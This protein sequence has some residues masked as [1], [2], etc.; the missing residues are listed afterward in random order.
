[1][2]FAD[3]YNSTN[4]ESMG[5]DYAGILA[6]TALV[7]VITRGLVMSGGIESILIAAIGAMFLFAAIGW[8]IGNVAARIVDESVRQRINAELEAMEQGGKPAESQAPKTA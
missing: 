7:T 8:L 3:R 4:L 2:R 5:R 1:M 6:T